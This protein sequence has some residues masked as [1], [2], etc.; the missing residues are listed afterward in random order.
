MVEADL[1]QARVDPDLRDVQAERYGGPEGRM[2]RRID[3]SARPGGMLI[4]SRRSRALTRVEPQD[5]RARR[6]QPGGRP[7]AETAAT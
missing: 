1:E 6:D 4:R 5:R 7:A 2:R 3:R